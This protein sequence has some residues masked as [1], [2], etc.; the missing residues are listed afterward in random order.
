MGPEV[1]A[2]EVDFADKVG[3]KYA[4]MVNSGSSANLL[5]IAALTFKKDNPLHAG[6]EIIVPALS[7]PTMFYP[8]CQYQMKLVFV[9]INLDE[10]NLDTRLLEDA[11][12]D[13]SKAI[14]VPHILGCPA[15]IVEIREFCKTHDLYLIEDNCESLG[16]TVDFKHTGTF[17]ICGTV[18]T[19]FCHHLSTME[20]GIVLTDNRE[21]YDILLALRA[22]GWTRDLSVDNALCKK[23]HDGFYEN[24]RF[25]LP[26]YNVRPL[27][28]S[29][30]IGREQLKKLDKIIETRR[31]NAN[32]FKGVFDDRFVL[33]KEYG[34]SSWFGFSMVLPM[35]ST[36][37]R[38]TV[39]KALREA[40][41]EVRPIVSGNFLESE[42][43]QHL[44][45]RIGCDNLMMAE[46]VHENG[47]YVG[48][49]PVDMRRQ[50]NLLDYILD[51]LDI[52]EQ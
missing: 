43:I 9:D 41:I 50:I 18:S 33:Q 29:A 2:Y 36:L 17:G 15:R 48:N 39:I 40:D 28:I 1:A 34:E 19:F 35:G 31:A 21:I 7:W 45:Y 46:H 10:L 51:S 16:A 32:Y 42:V 30:A 49:H 4:V 8:V 44:E 14:F 12:S 26:G 3:S 13:K 24:Y 47:F 5:V 20:G 52:R 23:N 27:E 6:D 37:K 11:L 38:S 25:V 22:H